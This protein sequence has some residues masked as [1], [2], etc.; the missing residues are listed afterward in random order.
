[1]DE[2][3]NSETLGNV[4]KKR[5]QRNVAQL[6]YLAK[7]FRFDI[8]LVISHLASKVQAPTEQDDNDLERVYKY[9]NKTKYR[10]M[11][12]TKGKI[13]SACAMIMTFMRMALR[14]QVLCCFYSESV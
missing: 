2:T 1:M 8:L 4:E 5:F 11:V 9:L 10:R 6:L 7:R 14:E 13:F 3:K 12:F